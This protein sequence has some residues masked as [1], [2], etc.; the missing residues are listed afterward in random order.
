MSST[1]DFDPYA[2]LGVP[3]DATLADIKTAR[4]KLALKYHPDK[5]KDKSVGDEFQCV[6]RAFELLSDETE[7]TKYDQKV[8]IQE[9]RREMAA[10]AGGSASYAQR[11][12]T[13][14]EYRDGRIYEERSPADMYEDIPYA[15][16]PRSTSRKNDEFGGMRQRTRASEEKKKTKSVP[17]STPRSTKDTARSGSRT[18]HTD[19][20]KYRTKERRR[21][22]YD[23]LYSSYGGEA[24][25]SSTESV[26]VRVKRPTTRRES[27]SRKPK[28][29]ESSRRRERRYEDDY[30]DGWDKH[31][32]LHSTAESYIRRSKGTIPAERDPKPR[33]SRSPLGYQGYESADP[34]SSSS[35]RVGRS[36]LSKESV[37]PDTSRHGSYEDLE[38]Y[39]HQ[40]RSYDSK[41]PPMPTAATTSGMKSSSS[42]RPSLQ[43]SR[44]ATA[45]YSRSKREGSSRSDPV[46]L[47]MVY[48]DPPP[49]T[50]K[51]RGAEKPDSG[52]SSP[53]TPEMAPGESPPKTR[54]KVFHDPI[55]DD[56]ETILVEP[57]IPSHSHPSPRHSRTY[58]PP[59]ERSTRAPPKPVRSSTYAY[60]P[61]SSKRYEQVRPETSRQSSSRLFGEVDYSSRPKEKDIRYA[62]EIGPDQIK[63]SSRHHYD[64]YHIPV[65]RRQS[66]YS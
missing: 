38:S 54:Y 21:E 42:A 36:R 30:S 24:S 2:V 25:D 15:K 17:L 34:E 35:R 27:S 41:I 29:A 58:L 40:S 47:G 28:P 12:S 45:S 57:S 51:A 53:G 14:R 50:T 43:P 33:S 37:R 55:V 52:Y 64:N 44:S 26:W 16:E 8:R 10:T 6:Q 56:P 49:R 3:K 4:R 46:L 22:A 23:K 19:R 62:R 63:Y 7:R 61:E 60:T 11:G 48:S 5:L 65:G 9:L 20:D 31:E 13:V 59:Q 18:T 32:K 66:T 39:E 1:L